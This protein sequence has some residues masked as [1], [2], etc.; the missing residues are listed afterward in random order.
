M[1]SIKLKH[2]SGN[3]TILNSPAANPTNDV[4]LK[5]P[6]TTGSAGQV[7]TEASANHSSTKAELEF[8]AASGG[9]ITHD[10]TY[11]L[12]ADVTNGSGGVNPVLPWEFS[13]NA[14]IG[15]LEDSNTW[16]LPSS[17][18]FS[19]PVTGIY[20]ISVDIMMSQVN[21]SN[22]W[23]G[24]ELQVT[25]NNGT[26]YGGAAKIYNQ[27]VQHS[28][29]STQYTTAHTQAIVDVTDI[30]Q[31]KYKIS[32]FADNDESVK[33]IGDSDDNRTSIKVIRLG[34]T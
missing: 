16:S 30:S 22:A 4:T 12:N 28:S 7:L 11:R 5:L 1:A 26:S 15:K 14:F 31:T 20:S 6:S 21:D 34:D 23:C 33:L 2:A 18:I 24:I 10:I 8:A 29:S 13:D 25:T 27:I 19:F 17:G 9:G 3:S 32:F